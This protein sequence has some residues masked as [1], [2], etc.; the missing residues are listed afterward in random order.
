MLTTELVHHVEGF[1][2]RGHMIE[3]SIIIPVYN[4]ERYL[5]RCLESI[6]PQLT[7][8]IEILV[9]DDAS[10]GN[11]KE[12]VACYQKPGRNI[13]LIRHEKNRSLM[14]SRITGVKNS[15]G[16]FVLHMDGDDALSE[17]T[18]R[19]IF[20]IISADPDV[21][22]IQYLLS[23]GKTVQE[24]VPTWHN[25]AEGILE[26]D[27]IRDV[28]YQGKLWWP[29]CGKVF[30]RE[31]CEKSLPYWPKDEEYIN[32]NEDMILFA[33]LL[34]FAKKCLVTRSAQYFYFNNPTSLTK[35]NIYAD[36]NRWIKLTS[37]MS[38][39][40]ELVLRFMV[41]AKIEDQIW[42]MEKIMHV[43]FVWLERNIRKLPD[44]LYQKR[45]EEL[46]PIGHPMLAYETLSQDFSSLCLFAQLVKP[47][48]KNI[49]TIAL[50]TTTI[51]LGGA[52]RVASILCKYFL[53]DGFSVY[54]F[55]DE[56]PQE[57]DYDY[58]D[59]VRRFVLPEKQS[60]RH[61]MI[62]ELIETCRID[63]CIM[64]SHHNRQTLYDLVSCRLAGSYVVAMEHNMFFYPFHASREYLFPLRQ[65]AYPLTHAIT[66]LSDE[67]AAWWF[68]AGFRQAI[69]IPNPLTFDFSESR[70]LPYVSR[71]HTILFVGKL[72]KAKGVFFIPHLLHEVRKKVPDAKLIMLGR[73]GM[74][75]DDIQKFESLIAEYG[76]EDF[77]IRLGHVSDIGKYYQ[78]ASVL[79]MPSRLEGSPMCLMEAKSFGIPA[80]VFEMEYVSNTGKNEGCLS[81]PKEDVEAMAQGVTRLLLDEKY[82]SAMSRDAINNLRLYSK[83]H[84]LKKWK[85]LFEVI[86]TG[87]GLS[88]YLHDSVDK[89]R[90]LRM[91]MK[92]FVYGTDKKD[93]V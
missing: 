67:M 27:E 62:V 38:R 66:C 68:Y 87:S 25:P 26:G 15:L 64:V 80:V 83:E 57:T 13:R 34:F 63:A 45:L 59:S 37:Q 1:G 72:M 23:A 61:S 22:I 92:E 9:I 28:F 85:T 42:A 5:P 31:L 7:P 10:P 86:S 41:E 53:E 71:K 91:T 69:H 77:I 82:W 88:E 11:C 76:L 89:E 39:A 60:D 3:L 78:D 16:R 46:M 43:N 17:N 40:R 56:P 93:W 55:T 35:G 65:K 29:L 6:I 33:P 84:I 75:N 51:G 4:V 50:F 2:E 12:I 52:E 18:C 70:V 21:D 58:P 48:R 44:K 8:E 24:M 81:V 32:S 36:E 74:S 20:N 30:S 14:Q 54:L 47:Q 73:Y 79:V 19:E 90:M 49:R